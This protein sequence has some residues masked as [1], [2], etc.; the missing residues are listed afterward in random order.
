[1]GHII[2]ERLNMKHNIVRILFSLVAC[3]CLAGVS[4]VAMTMAPVEAHAQDTDKVTV[5]FVGFGAINDFYAVVQGS[6]LAGKSLVI[7]QV[8]G[9]GPVLVYPLKKVS[10]QKALAS[11]EVAPYGIQA[12]HASGLVS[13]AG[14]QLG[15]MVVGENLQLTLSAGGQSMTLGISP[16]FTSADKKKTAEV[17]I[18]DAFWTPDSK[19]L[20]IIINQKLDGDWAIDSDMVMAYTLG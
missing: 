8:G 19:K 1:M 15:G 5:E 3:V 17:K 2:E 14:W 11:K 12:G 20:V 16:L 18:K 7:Y 13:P 6:E 4:F 10:L 9:Q